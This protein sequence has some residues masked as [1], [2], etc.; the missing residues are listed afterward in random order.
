LRGQIRSRTIATPILP[1]EL[2]RPDRKTSVA[3]GLA[4]AKSFA[5]AGGLRLLI[6]ARHRNIFATNT[7]QILT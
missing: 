2:L 6:A 4:R 1:P 3:R 5:R 7:A